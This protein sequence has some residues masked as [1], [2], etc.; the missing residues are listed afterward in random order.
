VGCPTREQ[1]SAYA[2]DA[3]TPDERA[4]VEGHLAECD[5]CAAEFSWLEQVAAAVAYADAAIPA[6]EEGL[7][8]PA[9]D[10]AEYAEGRGGPGFRGRV[11]RHLA[12]CRECRRTVGYLSEVATETG[13]A[14]SPETVAAARVEKRQR[15]LAVLQATFLPTPLWSAPVYAVLGAFASF[16][17]FAVL[18]PRIGHPLPVSV[19]EPA[20]QIPGAM[21]QPDNPE[22]GM[23]GMPGSPD[24]PMP[25]D[26][27]GTPGMPGMPGMSP[28]MGGM[29]GSGGM[30]PPPPPPSSLPPLP[31]M[32][33]GLKP[34]PPLPPMP[35][36]GN[37]GGRSRPRRTSSGGSP[38]VLPPPPPLPGGETVEPAP[39]PP[40]PK[41]TVSFWDMELSSATKLAASEKT[42]DLVSARDLYEAFLRH[43][44]GSNEQQAKAWERYAAISNKLRLPIDVLLRPTP[45]RAAAPVVVLEPPLQIGNMQ[46]AAISLYGEP[47]EKMGDPIKGETLKYGSR[48]LAFT[49]QNGKLV[50]IILLLPS[51]GSVDGIRVG[52]RAEGLQARFG[53]PT[54]E[55]GDG[56]VRWKY[57]NRGA[58]FTLRD[59]VVTRIDIK[60]PAS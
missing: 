22:N 31:P 54:K 19:R 44:A 33:E 35:S 17:L 46:T 37:P 51:A 20:N 15:T 59:G 26:M 56:F 58:Y 3:L 39:A 13:M 43:P 40:A 45:G 34:P 2:D 9:E 49:L 30:I 60:E 7:C 21:T 27:Q 53:D 1:L 14:V 52:D 29:P 41:P 8:L 48:G 10:L 18:L 57:P 24:N 16:L 38:N 32:D 47:S 23:P 28:G 5:A 42:E 4:Q 11:E 6:V 55:P 12:A 50:A 36:M 25:P